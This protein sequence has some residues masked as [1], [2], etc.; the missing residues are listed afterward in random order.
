M[1]QQTECPLDIGR[2]GQSD[3]Q[4]FIK[5]DNT[6][7]RSHNDQKMARYCKDTH[8]KLNRLCNTLA[9]QSPE[10]DQTLSRHCQTLDRHSTDNGRIMLDTGLKLVR[11]S[12][13]LALMWP[14]MAR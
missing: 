5:A 2:D 8:Q 6:R 4:T 13:I 10:T 12:Q 14:E 7:Q 3:G 9:R 1:D 11:L